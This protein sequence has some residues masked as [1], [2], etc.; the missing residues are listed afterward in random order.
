M[1]D[2]RGKSGSGFVLLTPL[3]I[4]LFTQ[5]KE[6]HGHPGSP[7]SATDMFI[8]LIKFRFIKSPRTSRRIRPKFKLRYINCCGDL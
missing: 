8:I 4:F 1:A 3:A 6:G 7:G 5:N 2:Q